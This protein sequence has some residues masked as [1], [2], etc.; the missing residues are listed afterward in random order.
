MA[1]ISTISLFAVRSYEGQWYAKKSGGSAWVDDI[2][3]ARMYNKIRYARQIASW[4]HGRDPFTVKPQVIEFVITEMH[5]V[6]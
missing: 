3:E 1:K 4:F 2:K 6:E 5:E